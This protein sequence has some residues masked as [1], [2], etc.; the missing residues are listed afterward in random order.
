MI[1]IYKKLI[2]ISSITD[3]TETKDRRGPDERRILI[4]KLG[5]VIME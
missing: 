3:I 4:Q 1:K 2:E 5:P